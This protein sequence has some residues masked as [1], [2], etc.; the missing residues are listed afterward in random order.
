MNQPDDRT[1]HESSTRFDE[2]RVGAAAVY[3]SDGRFGEHFD[4]FLH[5][6][7]KLPRYDRL[8]VPG[9]AACLAGH[10]LA[11]REEEGMV[12]QLRFLVK[13]HGLERVVLIAHQD[14]A[15]YT[16]RLHVPPS[17]LES[18]QREDL[19]AAA[20]RVRAFASGLFVE[21]F[22]ARK[23]GDGTVRFESLEQPSSATASR[24]IC[25]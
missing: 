25:R 1:V 20:G 6:T 4:E 19:E 17:R 11:F 13:V 5:N 7:L 12:E 22:F 24:S 21:A 18:Q 2:N 23:Q 10:F 8:A 14:C 16:E 9:G 15:F 3:C